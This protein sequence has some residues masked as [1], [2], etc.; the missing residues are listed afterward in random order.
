MCKAKHRLT[1]YTATSATY[2]KLT[3]Q[4]P[5]GPSSPRFV[6]KFSSVKVHQ[7]QE[8]ELPCI[9]EG[10][11]V[12][13]V[14]WY[15]EHY[16]RLEALPA[17]NRV[18]F[19]HGILTIRDTERYD[20]GLY[21]CITNNSVEEKRTKTILK[22]TSRL[23]VIVIPKV[24]IVEVGGIAVLNCTIDGFPI[25]AITWLKDKRPLVIDPRISYLSK[26]VMKI[27]SVRRTDSGMYQ[28]FIFNDDESAQ[29]TSELTIGDVAPT[30]TS[31]FQDKTVHPG[32]S[33]YLTCTATANPIP[34]ITWFVDKQ[35]V[36]DTYRISLSSHMFIEDS[37]VGQINITDTRVEDG[38]RYT[39]IFSN[40]VGSVEHSNRLNVHGPPFIRP[41]WNMTVVSSHT[42]VLRCPYGGFPVDRITWER[43]GILLPLSHREEVD[44]DGTLTIRGVHKQVDEG[45]YTCTVQNSEGQIAS[46]STYISVVVAPVIDENFFPEKVT[47][48]EGMTARLYC[49]VAE[50]E[51]PIRIHW[52]KEGEILITQGHVNVENSQEYSV[53]IFKHVTARENGKYTCIASNSAASVNK[54]TELTVN[55]PPRWI[56]SPTNKSAVEG[57]NVYLDCSA[58]G[59]PRPVITWRKARGDSNIEGFRFLVICI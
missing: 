53:I 19:N 11:P 30:L 57:Q 34:N 2:G 3:I 21:V 39:C 13:T 42:I 49:S 45:K 5:H 23:K 56:I 31:S 28:C 1:G 55:V 15:K 33:V 51:P 4:E 22:V 46:G 32:T 50:G 14:R 44:E 59:L 35:P 58:S 26:T 38:G 20:E 37:I 7:G 12:P 47:V 9:V 43:G 27:S 16:G 29:G 24:Q 52:E 17:T 6:L 36:H 8:S 54:T 40:G 10:W 48:T 25:T 41:M 18:S